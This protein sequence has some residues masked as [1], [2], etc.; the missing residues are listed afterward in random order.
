[1]KNEADID[2][3]HLEVDDW[4]LYDGHPCQISSR[5]VILDDEES[6]IAARSLIKP[7][8]ISVVD[9]DLV[10]KHLK[11]HKDFM[12]TYRE[13]KSLYGVGTIVDVT[14]RNIDFNMRYVS[15]NIQYY[16]ELQHALRLIKCPLNLNYRWREALD[17]EVKDE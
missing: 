10:I 7:L 1:M 16:H 8:P 9:L 6:T 3:R 11:K 4:V 13:N 5:G 15:T 17:E 14:Y 2:I 12:L